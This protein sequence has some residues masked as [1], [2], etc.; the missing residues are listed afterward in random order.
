MALQQACQQHRDQLLSCNRLEFR[1][2]SGSL[3]ESA[4]QLLHRRVE[5]RGTAAEVWVTVRGQDYVAVLDARTYR[6]TGRITVP[7]GLG[8][9]I[10]SPDGA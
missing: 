5:D 1:T 10:F 2:T 4:A 7:N 8:M 3:I 6:E 9:T